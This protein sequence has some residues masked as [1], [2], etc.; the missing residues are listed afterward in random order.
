[1]AV[2]HY[3]TKPC[4]A[5]EPKHITQR[6]QVPALPG[7]KGSSIQSSKLL[8]SE[9]A[10]NT[11]IWI[12]LADSRKVASFTLE[13]N[14]LSL[15]LPLTFRHGGFPAGDILHQSY[16]PWCTR[17]HFKRPVQCLLSSFQVSKAG[18]GTEIWYLAQASHWGPCTLLQYK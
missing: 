15:V 8:P 1:M 13:V 11:C 16:W 9:N 6:F 10:R 18:V 14:V 7:G 5:E 17:W 4:A 12:E 2:I 3:H